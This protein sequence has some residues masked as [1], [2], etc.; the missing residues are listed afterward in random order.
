[1]RFPQDRQPMN[2][3]IIPTLNEVENIGRLIHRIYQHMN[4]DSTRVIV[5]DDDSTD[6]TQRAV[7]DLEN[8]YPRLKLVVR[9]KE[10]GLSTAVKLGASMVPE[11]PV[12]VMDAD[13]SHNPKFLP[14]MFGAL[15][16]GYD[17]V[18]G[19]RYVPDG[20]IVGW[21]GHRIAISKGAT[22]IARFLLRLPV[23]DPMSG[24]VGCRSPSILTESINM[25][26]YKFLVEI[27]S[28]NTHLNVSEVPI[29]FHDR[30]R[31]ES[32]LSEGTI[33]QYLQLVLGL[34]LQRLINS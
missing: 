20:A 11:G 18:V 12:V 10:R 17:I 28:K 3:V 8:K 6:G 16:S 7:R 24:F 1:M 15:E 23:K 27:L 30:T 29:V 13:M 25:A 34:F 33:V 2:S 5:V 26:N 9:T 4:P 19:S 14:D 21:K 22:F 32:K 31:G